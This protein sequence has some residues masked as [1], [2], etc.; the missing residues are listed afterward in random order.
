M[1]DNSVNDDELEDMFLKIK[2]LIIDNKTLLSYYNWYKF[3]QLNN[4]NFS[5]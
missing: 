3:N 1:I 5:S 4:I 2:K